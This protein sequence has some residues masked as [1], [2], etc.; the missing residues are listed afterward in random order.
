[1]VTTA[2]PL[3]SPLPLLARTV[4][5]PVPLEGEVYRPLLLIVPIPPES[6]LQVKLG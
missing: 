1:M 4:T 3:T 6:M 5:G 2:L